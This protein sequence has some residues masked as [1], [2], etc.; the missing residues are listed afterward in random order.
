[1]SSESGESPAEA[2]RQEIE[3]IREK[4]RS[5]EDPE[6]RDALQLKITHL[7]T[8]LASLPPEEPVEEEDLTPPTPQ[9]L[10]EADNLIRQ[11][12]VEKMRGNTGQSTVLLNKAAE[13]APTAPAVLEALADDLLER[14]QKK[15][16]LAVYK[17]A[18]KLDPKNV[19]LERKYATLVLSTGPSVTFEDAMR[20]DWNESPFLSS[21]DH[22][23]SASAA[24][25]LSVLLP[26]LGHIILGKTVTGACI[27]AAWVV[28][29]LWFGIGLRGVSLSA[30]GEAH[31]PL[32]HY[33]SGSIIIPGILMSIIFIGTINSL[34]IPKKLGGRGKVSRPVPPMN[35]P[36]D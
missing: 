9:Q 10:A 1:M 18:V 15:E 11:A 33:F 8:R 21:E 7:E 4:Q 14:K 31:V 22:V 27:L 29:F 3:R 20:A 36:F 35:L 25:L 24:T 23:A 5:L 28:S 19:G 26:G 2:L 13:A 6:L 17:R 30:K 16:A 12:R 34:R 32:S